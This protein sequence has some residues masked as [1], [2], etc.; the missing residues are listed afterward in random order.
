MIV[1]RI[2]ETYIFW[3]EKHANDSQ[4]IIITVVEKSILLSYFKLKFFHDIMKMLTLLSDYAN[5]KLYNVIPIN[6]W[7]SRNYFYETCYSGHGKRIE[8]PYSLH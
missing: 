5:T 4:N 3:Y 8:S 1:K 6:I 7:W 2:A